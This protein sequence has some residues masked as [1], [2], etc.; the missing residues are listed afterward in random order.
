MIFGHFLYFWPC[1][2]PLW[3]I[4]AEK[5]PAERPNGHLLENWRYPKLPQDIRDLGSHWVGSAW[6]QKLVAKWLW[7]CNKC[8]LPGQKW[9]WRSPQSSPY[10][11]VNTRMLS[12]WCPSMMVTTNLVDFQKTWIFVLKNRIFCPKI[13]ILLCYTYVSP[14]VLGST[15][16]DSMG[17]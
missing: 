15:G 3:A 2:G 11:K 12:F 5:Q 8:I 14:L 17:S 10:N 9:A 6:P 13:S 4:G 16:P 1:Q 7:L